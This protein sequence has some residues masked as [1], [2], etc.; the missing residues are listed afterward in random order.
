MQALKLLSQK[1]ATVTT[2]ESKKLSTF[3]EPFKSA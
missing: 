2:N 3:S 1:E